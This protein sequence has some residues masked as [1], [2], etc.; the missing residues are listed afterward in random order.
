MLLLA[1]CVILHSCTY[2]KKLGR[3]GFLNLRSVRTLV[4]FNITEPISTLSLT[5]TQF[6]DHI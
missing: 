6:L 5:S 4:A 3:L 1:E 2:V